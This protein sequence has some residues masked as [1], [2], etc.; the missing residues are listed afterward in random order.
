MKNIMPTYGR[1]DINLVKGSGAYVYDKDGKEYLDF[2]SGIA[3]NALGHCHPALVFALKEQADV[4]WHTSNIFKS[5]KAEALAEKL[6]DAS[7][8]DLVFFCNSGAEAV[9]GVIKTIRKHFHDKG[10]ENKNR[11]ITFDG[12][13]HGRTIGT[14]SATFKNTEGFAPVLGGFDQA[15]FNDLESVKAIINENTAGILVEPIQGEGGVVPASEEFLQGLRTLCDE[16]NILL[17]FDEVQSGMGRAGTLWAHQSYG[18]EPD[19]MAVAKGLGGGFP[20]GAILA[21]THASSG[22]VAGTHGSTF[23]GNPLAIAV[24]TAV[25][26]IVKTDSFLENVHKVGAYMREKLRTLNSVKL[27]RGKGL[28][29]GIMFNDDLK[30]TDV[31]KSCVDN[32]LLVVK[33]G[34][35]C[36]RFLSPLIINKSHA[37]EAVN[38]LQK[39]IS[40]KT[41]SSTEG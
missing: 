30:N 34:E 36:L 6:C 1:L 21:T 31:L 28:F 38:K 32:G 12:A 11:I 18:V 24:A 15:V 22:M 17:A 37:D 9:E 5:D 26:D 19:V 4:L 33:A 2:C 35:N 8:A 23:G 14:I 20:I 27:V 41:I 29:I 16:H 39:A 13:F 40:S 7:F 3:V 10:L 25:F